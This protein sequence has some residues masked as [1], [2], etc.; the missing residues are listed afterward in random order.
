MRPTRI[1]LIDDHALVRVTLRDFIRATPGMEVVA[2]A[3]SGDDALGLV[4][5]HHPDVVVLD[6]Q[7]P[8]RTCFDVAAAIAQT[9]P[10]TRVV[11]LSGHTSDHYIQ[12]ALD[13]KVAGYVT[14]EDPPETVV[15]AVRAAAAGGT[16][17]SPAVRERLR[18]GADGVGLRRD[19]SR[20]LDSLSARE[21]EVLVQLARGL[22]LKEVAGSLHLSPKTI[23][24]HAQRLMAKLDIHS[25]AD[26]V[27]FAIREQ[28]VQP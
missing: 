8:G 9:A 26:L 28:L 20:P 11:L 3:G 21:M 27:R 14:K 17:F 15:E 16:F 6:I 1:V 23:D 19:R 18:S 25:R 5:E 12:K 2:V 4:A 22:S 10:Q 7:M 13:A 24:N